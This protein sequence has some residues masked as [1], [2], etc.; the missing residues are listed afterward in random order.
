MGRIVSTL[1][2]ARLNPGSYEVNFDSSNFPGGTYF[3]S[4]ETGGI[5]ETKKMIVLK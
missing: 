5:T 2:N 1:V 4:L 3:Y